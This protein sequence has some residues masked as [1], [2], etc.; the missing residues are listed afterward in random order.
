MSAAQR[1]AV[2][3]GTAQTCDDCKVPC[4]PCSEIKDGSQKKAHSIGNRVAIIPS[5]RVTR[6]TL[7][8]VVP[9]KPQSSVAPH[10]D[11]DKEPHHTPLVG[12]H[13]FNA[14]LSGSGVCGRS[15][16]LK[17]LYAVA[18]DKTHTIATRFSFSFSFSS[19][20]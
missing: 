10:I 8:S 15:C 3:H 4:L 19:T 18:I 16:K 12:F 17:N 2:W 1:S 13:F 20:I 9:D 14:M 6:H 5:N 11:I 7:I